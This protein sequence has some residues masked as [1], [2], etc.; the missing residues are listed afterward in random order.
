[1]KLRKMR[2]REQNYFFVDFHM[3][4]IKIILKIVKFY[5]IQLN[6]TFVAVKYT[7]NSLKW[8]IYNQLVM[9]L[10]I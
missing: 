8:T 3:K 9:I 4:I 1:M 6:T 2:K 7:K 10:V 5:D